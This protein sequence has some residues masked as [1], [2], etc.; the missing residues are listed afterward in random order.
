MRSALA[1]GVMILEPLNRCLNVYFE[2]NL[3]RNITR[4]EGSMGEMNARGQR[5]IWRM[6]EEQEKT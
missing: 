5:Y 3:T 1:I 2:E 6:G 4:R